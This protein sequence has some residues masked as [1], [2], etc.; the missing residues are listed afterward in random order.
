MQ[1]TTPQGARPP[2]PGRPPGAGFRWRAL[3]G[4]LDPAS[5]LGEVLFGLIMVLSVTLTARLTMEPG[6]AGLTQLL[7]ATVGCN[8]AWGLIDAIMYVMGAVTERAEKSALVRRVRAAQG[9]EE[10]IAI[11]LADVESRF[12]AEADPLLRRT[13]ARG[14][15]DYL[16]AAELPAPGI[17]RDDMVGAFACFI[18]VVASCLPVV[19][20]YLVVPDPIAAVRWANIL[21]IAMLFAAGWAWGRF[22]HANALVSAL[23]M[24]T[25]GI[26]LSGLAVLLGG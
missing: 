23:L 20:V 1:G 14:I 11:V 22:A 18:L 4:V 6:R 3:P 15:L 16:R 26:V 13:L 8:I 17:D 25:I 7:V 12:E 19:L 10:A 5:R 21:L 2:V 24:V 9:E